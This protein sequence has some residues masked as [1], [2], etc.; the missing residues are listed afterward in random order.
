MF[1]RI[2]TETLKILLDSKRPVKIVDVLPR[3]NYEKEHIKGAVSLPADEIREK[4][5]LV[6][7][8][9][10]ILVIYSASHGCMESTFAAAKLISMGYKNIIDYKPGLA[11]YK[12]AGLPLEG[13]YHGK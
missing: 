13:E 3:T 6:A 12:D 11:A 5:H 4:V 8:K 2:S 9:E 10:D 7:N 1:K